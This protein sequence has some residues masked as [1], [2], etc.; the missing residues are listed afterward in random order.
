MVI[1][2]GTIRNFDVVTDRPAFMKNL[3]L[4]HKLFTKVTQNNNNSKNNW[5][6]ELESYAMEHHSL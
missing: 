3:Y 6:A 5:Y 4:S 2:K 1:N